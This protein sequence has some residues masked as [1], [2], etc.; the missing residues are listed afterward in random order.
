LLQRK[1]RQN[2]PRNTNFKEMVATSMLL[3]RKSRQNMPRN[4][5]FPRK[6]G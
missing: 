1:S 5:I 6:T 3:Q 4:L 2:M